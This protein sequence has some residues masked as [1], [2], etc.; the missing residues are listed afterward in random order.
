MYVD[1]QNNGILEK[2]Y[3]LFY[4]LVFVPEITMYIVFAY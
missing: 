3:D 2:K 1:S 4:I